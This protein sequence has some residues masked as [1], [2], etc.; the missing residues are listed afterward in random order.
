ML[1]MVRK[2]LIPLLLLSLL[3]VA[4]PGERVPTFTNED[5]K[6]YLT[7]PPNELETPQQ[8]TNEKALFP[9]DQKDAAAII[10]ENKQSIVLIGALDK[11]GTIYG[12]GSGFV[13]SRDGTV[14]T[15]YHVIRNA[16]DIRIKAGDEIYAVAGIIHVDVEH[17]IALLKAEG[18]GLHPVRLGKSGD[19]SPGEKV[20][21]IANPR[22]TGLALSEGILTEIREVAGKG[23][24]LQI[25]ASFTEGYSGSPVFNEQG[26]VIGMATFI[27]K[28][29]KVPTAYQKLN[30]AVPVD[31]IRESA[32]SSE[33]TP[34][35]DL[36]T[37]DYRE[38]S[39]Y[40]VGLGN[41]L[42]GSGRYTEAADAYRKALEIDPAD[43]EAL[44]GLG[45]SYVKLKKNKEAI[46]LF[47]QAIALGSNTAWVYSNLGLAYIEAR[48]YKEALEPLTQAT[49]I[50][51]ELEEAHYNLGIGYRN[52][53]MPKEAIASFKNAVSINPNSRDAH[54]GLGLAFMDIKDKDSALEEYSL[55]KTLDPSLAEMLLKRIRQ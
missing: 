20:Y 18:N 21:V 52:L 29:A 22:G 54:F 49:N 24:M 26:E 37:E 55:L 15:S 39:G 40:W 30:F 41:K 10:R 3:S 5:L 13:L 34:M 50:M 51:P 16:A 38:T 7:E 25:T 17:D 47:K 1:E 44:N 2:T 36:R 6:K 9:S 32:L 12:H 14:V 53:G 19:I 4:F 35:K 11:N 27:V 43:A 46:E 42:Y 31:R 8:D 28:G 33:F 45:I 23:R 48:M